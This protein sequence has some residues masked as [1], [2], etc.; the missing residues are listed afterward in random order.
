MASTISPRFINV[1]DW[2]A[3]TTTLLA[4]YGTIPKLLQPDNWRQW[5][6]FVIN[7]PAISAL[8]PPRPEGYETWDAWARQFNV[9]AQLL[10]A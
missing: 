2:T 3:Q 6:A 1:V 8:N 9:A 7:L 4:P 10:S 5:A